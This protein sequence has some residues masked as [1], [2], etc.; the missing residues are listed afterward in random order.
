MR[1]GEF[2][3][4]TTRAAKPVAQRALFEALEGRQLLSGVGN[5]SGVDGI[6]P[7]PAAGPSAGL[8][9]AASAPASGESVKQVVGLNSLK[10]KRSPLLMET[11]IPRR[12]DGPMGPVA[13][14]TPPVK[15]TPT[16][17]APLLGLSVA[18]FDKV[19]IFWGDV[20]KEEV[21]H[22]L[23]STDGV[24]FT[25]VGT[26][27]ANSTSYVDATI[28]PSTAYQYKVLS[29]AAGYAS[30][31]S[32]SLAIETYALPA[33]QLVTTFGEAG[34]TKLTYKG[35]TLLD[36]AA[37][38]GDG[39]EVAAVKV[40]YAD[41][42]SQ[43]LSGKSGVT[44][45]VD[46]ANRTITWSYAW[47]AVSAKYVQ[48]RDRLKVIVTVTNNGP[49]TIA[50][51]DVFPL[52]VRFGQLPPGWAHDLP[53]IGFNSDGPT[54]V[55]ADLGGGDVMVLTNEDV[56]R[57]LYVGWMTDMNTVSTNRYGL[58]VGSTPLHYQPGSWPRFDQP[59]PSGSS[60]SY[61]ISLRFGSL[62]QAKDLVADVYQ[63]AA[64]EYPPILNWTDRRG[65]GTIHLASNSSGHRSATNPRGFFNDPTVDVFTVEGLERFR[66]TL[67]GSADSTIGILKEVG[68]QGAIVWDLE[69]QEYPHD[70]SYIGDPRLVGELAPEME[71]RG[72]VDE[73][74]RRF[75]DAGLRVGV[76]IRAQHFTRN[77][78]GSVAQVHVEDVRAELAAKIAYARD[79][80][81]VTL[82]YIDSNIDANFTVHDANMM[83]SLLEQ[84]PDIL[85]IPEH[86]TAKYHG[87]AAPYDE[88]RSG[89]LGTAPEVRTF[90][91]DGFSVLYT[92]GGDLAGH[93]DALVR[94]VR[95]G[96]VLL[97][98]SWYRNAELALVKQIY[99]AAALQ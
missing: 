18:S 51:V 92:G 76:A 67:L 82:F 14:G 64:E 35:K 71:Y 34:L 15:A 80:W 96:D 81:G 62:E 94:A 61:T 10:L 47:G 52:A 23:R 58:L 28:S 43:L 85:L 60:D 16:L 41:G 11:V 53:R 69:G 79:R 56:T 75:R 25:P 42:T 31:T 59:V 38:P 83:K 88:V 22:V 5:L 7:L 70:I 33:P 13:P 29:V 17:A 36:T 97:F 55:N 77:G 84:F 32:Q 65:I 27:P 26:A 21:Y 86:E 44:R 90:A 95:N 87:Y 78:D 63:Q 39:F 72:A 8:P 9:L 74:F 50:G 91:P 19:T 30:G 99:E 12:Q 98:E 1:S 49:D 48:D 20:P 4:A 3:T 89:D 54:V 46:V 73:Y 66:A 6:D 68:A 40:A 57:E 93:F 37:H 24:N 45:S 2:T